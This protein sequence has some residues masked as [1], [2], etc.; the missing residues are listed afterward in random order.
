MSEREVGYVLYECTPEA[1]LPL[2]PHGEGLMDAG[3][4]NFLAATRDNP[5]LPLLGLDT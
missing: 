2:G 4:V 3:S 5:F 1:L